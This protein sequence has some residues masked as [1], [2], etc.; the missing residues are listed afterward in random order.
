MEEEF[1]VPISYQES[2]KA[3]AKSEINKK[4][5]QSDE[6]KSPTNRK[7]NNISNL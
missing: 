4:V 6:Y 1:D 2:K 5:K 3:R 7:F